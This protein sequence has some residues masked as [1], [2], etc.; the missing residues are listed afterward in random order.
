LSFDYS[1]LTDNDWALFLKDNVLSVENYQTDVS[2]TK[3][4]SYCLARFTASSSKITS[5]YWCVADY[6]LDGVKFY[7]YY[8]NNTAITANDSAL[9]GVINITHHNKTISL[10]AGGVLNRS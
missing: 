3:K 1:A 8:E 5:V 10:S 7:R 6:L 9:Y 4:D 2:E